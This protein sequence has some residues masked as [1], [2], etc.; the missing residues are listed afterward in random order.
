MLKMNSFPNICLELVTTLKIYFRNTLNLAYEYFT[1]FLC[2]FNDLCF[3]R[4]IFNHLFWNLLQVG[5]NLWKRS[6]NLP[7]IFYKYLNKFGKNLCSSEIILQMFVG[8]FELD[9]LTWSIMPAQA[10]IRRPFWSS[11]IKTLLSSLMVPSGG[12]F[13]LKFW[14][15]ICFRFPVSPQILPLKNL[16]FGKLVSHDRS[17]PI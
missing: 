3:R 10:C 1:N 6:A 16:Q 14:K 9:N 12:K 2:D 17:V 15:A 4:Q 13:L 7:K 5:T 8:N 11:H